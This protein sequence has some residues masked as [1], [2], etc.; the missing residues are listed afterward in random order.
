MN[1]GQSSH[2]HGLWASIDGV[3]KGRLGFSRAVVTLGR[4]IAARMPMMARTAISSMTVNG[5]AG[6]R[7]EFN[8]FSMLRVSR[9]GVFVERGV[10]RT[11]SVTK[12]RH[13]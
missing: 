4:T 9:P 7:D 1:A 5:V 3:P 11:V 10:N 12:Y 2:G 8:E 6:G 13:K